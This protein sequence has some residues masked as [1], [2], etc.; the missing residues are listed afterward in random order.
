[1]ARSK[2]EGESREYVHIDTEE[3]LG[4]YAGSALDKVLRDDPDYERV[5]R[6]AAG[7]AVAEKVAVHYGDEGDGEPDDIEI[8]DLSGL[9]RTQ[10]DELA[11]EKGVEDPAGLP[12]KD[13]VK[14]AILATYGDEGE[15]EE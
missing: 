11:S 6:R 13:A 15:A 9:D 14:A 1:M 3:T 2:T 4:A 5:S 8:P 12:N 10:L 7:R